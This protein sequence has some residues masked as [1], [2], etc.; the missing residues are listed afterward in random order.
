MAFHVLF[1]ADYYLESDG[2][3]F[4]GQSFHTANQ[5]LFDDYEQLQDCEPVAVY[6]K[7]QI[8]PYVDFCR[9]KAVTITAAETEL[10]LAQTTSLTRFPMSRFELHLYNI[11]HL[12]HH[13]AQLV[14]RLR[15][16]QG[17]DIPWISSGW[18]ATTTA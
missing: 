17:V 9:H 1:F 11:R 7:D 2:G 6:R 12:Q 3:D 4:R 8:T 18:R 13:G 15:L 5:A 16:A 14:L 10:S